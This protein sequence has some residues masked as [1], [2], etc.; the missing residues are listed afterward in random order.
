MYAQQPITISG[1]VV[2]GTNSP[3]PGASVVIKGRSVGTVADYN[4]AYVLKIQSGETLVFSFVGMTSKEVKVTTQ[5][6][7]NVALE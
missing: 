7:I 2:D 5:R 4:G 1:K 3:L 6:I